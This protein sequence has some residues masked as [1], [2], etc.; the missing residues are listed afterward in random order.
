MIS[1]VTRRSILRWIHIILSIP[2]GGYVYGQPSEVKQYADAVR[3]A[4]FPAIVV[5]GL[6]MWKGHLI[7][8]LILNRST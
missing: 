3:F 2:I 8:R 4:F 1:D 6:W 5:S 7:R